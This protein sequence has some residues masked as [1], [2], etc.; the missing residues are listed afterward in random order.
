MKPHNATHIAPVVL[1]LCLTLLTACSTQ[2]NTSASRWWHSFHARYNTYFNGSQAYI[3][4]SLE[5]ENGNR[6]NYTELLPL[7][8]VGNK[9][10]RDLGKG[11]F[12]RAV[13]K[14][15][16]AIHQHSIRRRPVWDKQRRKTAK[17]IEWLN[18]REYN[19]FLWKAW[20]LMG[21]AQFHMG[22][23][24]EA[25]ST[26]SYMSRLYA[27][28]PAIYGRAR[29][30]L[31]KSYIEQGWMYDA[32]D[33]IRNMQRDSIHWRAVKE[34]DYTY[35]DYY[36]HT[37]EYEKAIPYLQ[38]V[39]K[40]E[41]RRKQKAREWYIMGQ[42]QAAL[43][44]KQEAYRAFRRVVR[45]NPPYEL[46]FN[47]RIAMSEVMAAGQSKQMIRRLQRMAASDNNK[48]YQDQIYYAIGNI[49]LADRD[50]THAIYAY[51]KG[52]EKATRSGIEKGVLLLRLGDL[53]WQREKFS[54]ANRCYGEAIGLLDQD[55]PDYKQLSER[56]RI[57]EKLVPYTEAVQL[58]DS[59]QALA[60]MN[61]TDRNAAIDRVI[62]AFKQK[63]KKERNAQADEEAQRMQ[64]ESGGMDQMDGP[65]TP[66][67]PTQQ[68]RGVWYFY[69]PIAVSQGKATFQRLWGKRE[70]IDNWQRVN[71]TVVAGMGQGE[72]QGSA[73]GDSLDIQPASADSLQQYSD[74]IQSDPHRRE[75]YLA[76][77]PFTPEQLA[78]SNLIL[79]DGLYNSGVIFK[80]ELNNL[81]LSERNLRRLVDNYPD[82][83]H[84][85]DAYYHLF[86][87]Y[88]RLN[89]PS[90][91]NVYLNKLSAAYP[92]SQWTRILTD[93]HYRDNA[94]FGV[95]LEDSL[96]ASTYNA[97]KVGRYG[98]VA[99]NARLSASR[100]PLGAN[101][102]KFIFIGG[103]SKLNGGDAAG[104]LADMQTLVRDYPQSELSEMAGMIVNGVNAGR[105]LRG[106]RFDI[107]DVWSRRSEVLNDSDSIA[108]RTFNND[109]QANFVFMVVYKP[110]S[111]NENQ[112]LFEL[113]KYNFT[114]FLVRNFGISI[115]DVDGLHR[116]QVTGFRSYDEALQYA[117]QFH[118]Q[119]G[120]VKRLGNSRTIIISEPNLELLGAPFSYDDYDKFYSKH[121][122]PLKVSTYRLLTEPAEITIGQQ[123]EPTQQEIDN[124]LD[125]GTI[126]DNGLE[127]P[128]INT[129]TYVIPEEEP[130]AK[131]RTGTII[132]PENN[133]PQTSG[134][135]TTIVVPEQKTAEKPALKPVTTP[136]RQPETVGPVKRPATPAPPAKPA[137]KTPT[138]KPAQPKPAKPA[139]PLRQKDYTGIY[140]DDG[141]GYDRSDSTAVRNTKGKPGSKPADKSAAKKQEPKKKQTF[142]LEDEY[143]ELEGF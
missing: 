86:L 75:Y 114:N 63:E 137:A 104:C 134:Q 118:R 53:Y 111:V 76:Q 32:E 55:R 128:D 73:E 45:M 101:R 91:A 50:T 117:R 12:E 30:W 78:A 1:T 106:G 31:A 81:K 14:S 16:K 115:E 9:N 98:E 47:A 136:R 89:M 15:E 41:M 37:G 3:D 105:R 17:D 92:H 119:A 88:S 7:Y 23:F 83:E 66:V 4:G 44:R 125:D 34:W 5:K 58:Q 130:V 28:Q 35:T 100:F 59:L 61:E 107:G 110:D 138:A 123:P 139:R 68:E 52:N 38:K 108:A 39:I 87:L 65:L 141:F 109:R 60:K 129:G 21:R 20:L 96:Y 72:F 127:Q 135:G 84:M 56:S 13:E 36:I 11:N 77:I 27:T 57:L 95:H 71:K 69:N 10:S 64:Q 2:K 80:D 67:A 82:Y 70:N 133:L 48:D 51:E 102:D 24:E 42:L 49:Y 94:R 143:Y 19:P 74:S 62:D 46:E 142:D 131:P 126:I 26:F 122:A 132:E 25:A 103:L 93:P 99:A 79:E 33:V 29:A 116:M 6:D 40:H 43:G 120:I 90:I 8:T 22:S 18:R 121:F 112:L 140:F 124:V 54:E 97:F 85:D 113:A